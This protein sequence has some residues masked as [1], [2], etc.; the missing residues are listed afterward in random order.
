MLFKRKKTEKE[1]LRPKKNFRKFI[2][3]GF[4]FII[5]L[6]GLVYLIFYSPYLKLQRIEVSGTNLLST[7]FLK[8]RVAALIIQDNDFWKRVGS[9]NILFWKFSQK[10]TTPSTF[11]PSVA[12]INFDVD[13]WNRTLYFSV[14]ERKPIGVWC[15][16]EECRSFD[17]NGVIF[18]EAPSVEGVL[19]LRVDDKS[20]ASFVLGESALPRKEW[21]LNMLKVIGE[22][23]SKNFQ[24]TSVK[25][26]ELELRDWQIDTSAGITML[27][28]FNFVPD[29]L[30]KVLEYLKERLARSKIKVLDFRVPNRIYYR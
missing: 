28:N 24:V 12:S 20:S 7:E 25:V 8:E 26:E 21:F 5:F 13:L 11:L 27:F 19:I 14:T 3:F 30:G 2:I 17:E 23:K 16:G 10:P 9:D 6:G 15:R 18:A 22:V 29:N 4:A 1:M